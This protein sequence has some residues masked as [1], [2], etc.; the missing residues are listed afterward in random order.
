MVHVDTAHTCQPLPSAPPFLT[1]CGLPQLALLVQRV[2]RGARC[3]G[4][5]LHP[6]QSRLRARRLGAPCLQGG[7]G[8]RRREGAGSR[9][10]AG[11]G[12]SHFVDADVRKGIPTT[13]PSSS[14]ATRACTSALPRQFSPPPPLTLSPYL[15]S[16]SRLATRTPWCSSCAHAL[17][18]AARHAPASLRRAGAGGSRRKRVTSRGGMGAPDL[19]LG[20]EEGEEGEGRRSREGVCGVGWGVGGG[21]QPWLA[22]HT[23]EVAAHKVQPHCTCAPTPSHSLRTSTHTHS[24]LPSSFLPFPFMCTS[25]APWPPSFLTARTPPPAGG[26]PGSAGGAGGGR[27]PGSRRA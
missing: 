12:A 13:T 26:V 17:S 19:T 16:S 14:P 9:G 21:R 8:E 11:A 10:T 4:L 24:S 23:H 7:R 15:S 25:P 2:R 3:R 27:L 5:R 22:A 18:S 6:P 20:G 1:R